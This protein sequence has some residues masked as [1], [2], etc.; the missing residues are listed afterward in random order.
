M[1]PQNF[2]SFCLFHMVNG[3]VQGQ[4]YPCLGKLL[5]HNGGGIGIFFVQQMVVAMQQGDLTPKP[6][7]RLGQFHIQSGHRQ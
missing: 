7:K 2:P 6:V 5:L 3:D 4:V 1:E